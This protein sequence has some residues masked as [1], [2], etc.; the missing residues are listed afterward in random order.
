MLFGG[1]VIFVFLCYLFWRGAKSAMQR[2]TAHLIVIQLSGVNPMTTPV[3]QKY[4][5]FST[6]TRVVLLA[7]VI[8]L[9]A[10]IVIVLV[11]SDGEAAV[12]AAGAFNLG[13]WIAVLVVTLWANWISPG[14]VQH[15][16]VADEAEQAQRG[17][18]ARDA[19]AGWN[20]A[21][22]TGLAAWN[23]QPLPP[24]PEIFVGE[25]RGQLLGQ[26]QVN[27]ARVV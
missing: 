19:V 10:A 4:R 22:I 27:T 24:E 13:R 1:F 3:Y 6:W 16:F 21:T 14:D 20:W 15:Y 17:Q 11:G 9:A 18:V 25:L 12:V 7:W 5:R 26:Q 23:G 8:D 2:T